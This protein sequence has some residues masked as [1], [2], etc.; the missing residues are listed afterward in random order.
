MYSNMDLLNDKGLELVELKQTLN[1]KNEL[2]KTPLK[3]SVKAMKLKS[4][5]KLSLLDDTSIE[6]FV[7][8]LI[9]EKTLVNQERFQEQ[10]GQYS[11]KLHKLLKERNVLVQSAV[12]SSGK[13]SIV[14][15]FGTKEGFAKDYLNLTDA[16][17][18][19]LKASGFIET[20]MGKLVLA[21]KR[22]MD[23]KIAPFCQQQKSKRNKTLKTKVSNPYF[24]ESNGY[25]NI[26]IQITL[27]DHT[28]LQWSS[29]ANEIA[30]DI[31]KIV[32]AVQGAYFKRFV[33]NQ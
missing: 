10:F 13:L 30:S 17:F 6:S 7:E 15:K 11:E 9:K 31:Q 8:R 20:F 5:I 26:E 2:V 18:D 1:T 4:A 32:T 24:D 19:E 23:K 14:K 33:L 25:Y 28:L 12:D 27:V 3:E 16:E 22:D 29:T 21:M